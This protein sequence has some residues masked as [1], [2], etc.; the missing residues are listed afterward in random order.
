MG[1]QRRKRTEVAPAR[2][3]GREARAPAATAEDRVFRAIHEAVLGHRLAPGTKL[4]ELELAELFGVTRAVVRKVLARLAHLQLVQLRP[5]RGAVVASPSVEEGIELFGARAAI[6]A[7]LA[8]RA[9]AR[10]TRDQLRELRSVVKQEHDAYRRGDEAEG[11]RRSVEFHRLLAG[12]AGNGVLAAFLDQLIART[13]LVVLAHPAGAN[14]N[15]CSIDEHGA[16]L[17]ALAAGDEARAARA[18]REHLDAVLGRLRL[19]RSREPRAL[20]E[21]LGVAAAA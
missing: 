2:A 11:H 17:D 9:T 10:I 18:M 5:N 8:E 20:A 7:A 12:V 16:I 21:M 6:E 3:R 19:Q 14:G 1:T 13:P 15:T 4:K